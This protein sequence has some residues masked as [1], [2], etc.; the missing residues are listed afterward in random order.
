MTKGQI[1]QMRA[2]M[3]QALSK[4]SERYDVAIEIG[5]IRYSDTGFTAKV[6]GVVTADPEDL[7]KVAKAKFLRE[8]AGDYRIREEDFGKK[9]T[10]NGR[11]YRIVGFNSRAHRYPVIAENING[12][13]YKFQANVI[14]S[15]KVN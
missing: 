13:K 10:E 9:F 3:N 7:E 5:T 12:V 6:E 14:P 4:I 1:K 15:S 8:I 11:Q 2:E